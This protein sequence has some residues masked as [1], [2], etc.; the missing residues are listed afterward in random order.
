M[1]DQLEVVK[2]RDLIPL[3]AIPRFV[4]GLGAPAIEVIGDDFSS[5]EQV[6]INDVPASEF[7]ILDKHR[8]YV[9]LPDGAQGPI[10]T[11]E[12]L[13][14][15]F[16]KT[17][18]ASKVTFALGN[19]TRTVHGVLKLV[20]LF[21]K[22]MLQSPGSDIYNPERGGGLQAMVGKMV[23][24][25]KM[26]PILTSITQAVQNTTQQIRAAQVTMS[27]LPLDERLLSAVVS[28]MNIFEE[29][30]EA[31]VKVLITTVAGTDAIASLDL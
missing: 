23:S 9:Q 24:T 13:S 31:R 19:K 1:S 10:S 29:Q 27:Q 25:R 5:V 17:T 2:F 14:S 15:N 11:I 30:M 7:I 6:F 21:T 20:Q 28:D 12:V 3:T 4:P 8:M 16:T 18:T 22:W 26:D